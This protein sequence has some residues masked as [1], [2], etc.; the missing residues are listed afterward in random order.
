MIPEKIGK[1]KVIGIGKNA[2]EGCIRLTI[3]AP[4]GSYAAN[5]AREYGINLEDLSKLKGEMHL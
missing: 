4:E 3:Y 1:T 5:Y 2:F